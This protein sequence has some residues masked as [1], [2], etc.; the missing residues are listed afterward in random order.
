ML[1][2]HENIPVGTKL[3]KQTFERGLDLCS[4]RNLDGLIFV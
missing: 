1:H 2:P 4:I 3:V